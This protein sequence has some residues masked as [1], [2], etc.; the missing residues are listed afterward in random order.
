MKTLQNR[1]QPDTQRSHTN[2]GTNMHR[3]TSARTD[4]AA[5]HPTHLAQKRGESDAVRFALRA[6]VKLAR[7]PAGKK[8]ERQSKTNFVRVRHVLCRKRQKPPTLV[9]NHTDGKEQTEKHKC[10]DMW[11]GMR[12]YTESKHACTR[13]HMVSG[14]TP[15]EERHSTQV[16][17]KWFGGSHHGSHRV[18]ECMQQQKLWARRRPNRKVRG[19]QACSAPA[20][21]AP[22]RAECVQE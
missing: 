22:I 17:Q 8:R 16:G 9:R 19:R 5:N 18:F 20:P 1:P 14:I 3:H 12:N 2:I 15:N 7:R 10:A 21:G 6:R 11:S 13:D 4:Q